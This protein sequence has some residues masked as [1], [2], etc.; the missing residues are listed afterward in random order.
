MNDDILPLWWEKKSCPGVDNPFQPYF[1]I[2]PTTTNEPRGAVIVCPGGGYAMRADYEGGAVAEHYRKLGLHA[3]VLQYRVAPYRHPEPLYDAAR[4]VRMVR[5]EADKWKIKPDKIAILGFSAGGHLAG[6]L[7]VH[8]EDVPADKDFPGIS[9]RP[10]ALILCYAVLNDHQGSFDNLMGP[11]RSPEQSAYCRL[12][13]YVNAMT[14]PAYLWHTAQDETVPVENTLDFAGALSQYHISFEM[15][16]FPM[17][18]HGIG[19]G[20]QFPETTV[21]PELSVKWLRNLGW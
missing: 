2:Y 14:P 5:A 20:E 8:Y 12:D 1:E 19:L 3:F 15:H 16:V 21:W 13:R 17:G 9:C 4:I 7:G 10:D 6:S 11:D 18:P